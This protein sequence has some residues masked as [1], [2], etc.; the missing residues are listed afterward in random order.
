VGLLSG[1]N[2]QKVVIGKWLV[3]GS[4]VIIM[5]QPT[6]G[7]DIS[8]KAE[9]YRIVEDLT[10]NG[11]AVLLLTQDLEELK[12]LS[13]RALVIYR[14]KVVKEFERSTITVEQVLAFS[15]G[16]SVSQ[17]EENI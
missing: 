1:G 3:R 10:Q 9:I 14:G 4:N 8:A 13:D 11:V 15:T 5:D 16:A 2:Q 12:G 6:V 7:V 17:G